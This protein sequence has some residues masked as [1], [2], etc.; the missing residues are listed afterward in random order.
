MIDIAAATTQAL[1][2][3]VD[4]TMRLQCLIQDGH[5]QLLDAN[6]TVGIDPVVRMAAQ[7]R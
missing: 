1:A 7:A 5:T 6:H 4:R 3:L 2:T